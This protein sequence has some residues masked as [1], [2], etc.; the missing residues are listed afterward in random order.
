MEETTIYYR[1]PDGSV[2]ERIITGGDGAVPPPGGAV[3]ITE[4]EYRAALAAIEE[5]IEQE[6]Q[7]QQEAEQAR[8][9]ADYDALRAL[10]VPEE[11]ARRLTGYTGPDDPEES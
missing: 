11:T 2:A 3:E 10:G 6:R 7:E 5:Q 4:E 8:I 1:F 9:K